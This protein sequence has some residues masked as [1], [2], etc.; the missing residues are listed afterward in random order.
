QP[1]ETGQPHKTGQPQ[2]IAPTVGNIVGAFKSLSTNEYIRGVNQLNW[3]SF[4][5]KLWQRNYYEHIIRDEE[6][7]NRIFEYIESNPLKWEIDSLHHDN[8]E[9][10]IKSE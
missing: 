6:D 8:F 5:K 2:G 9:K 7:Y 3:Q 1:P 10:E 4:N